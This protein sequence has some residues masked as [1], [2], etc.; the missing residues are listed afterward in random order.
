MASNFRESDMQNAVA[1]YLRD[2]KRLARD[3][4]FTHCPNELAIG[5]EA[6]RIN[7]AKMGRSGMTKGAPDF[8]LWL[9]K[10]R[11]ASIELKAKK[12][13]VTR[14][15]TAFCANLMALGHEYHLVRAETPAHA[16]TQVESII[17]RGVA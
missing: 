13:T 8:I 3:V 2:R 4:E 16:V 10:G 7:R 9:P 11:V 12:G 5:G 1:S 6:A 14:S 15:Q 17:G